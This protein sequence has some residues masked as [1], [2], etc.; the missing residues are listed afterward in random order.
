MRITSGKFAPVGLAC[1]L[2]VSAIFTAAH[3]DPPAP[4]A[5]QAK[6]PAPPPAASTEAKR[7][8]IGDVVF[9]GYVRGS[10]DFS[11]KA[12]LFGPNTMVEVPDK[13]SKSLLKI[14]ADEMHFLRGKGPGREI[15]E[16]HG[17]VRYAVTQSTPEGERRLNGTAGHGDF[18]RET[19][20]IALTNGVQCEMTDPRLDGPGTLR[21]GKVVVDISST[22]YLYTLDGD[23]GTNDVRFTPRPRDIKKNPNGQIG[24]V[25]VT[26]W[27][28]G[29]FQPGKVVSFDGQ[30]VLA[31]LQSR[32]GAQA[33]QLKAR[34][35][36]GDFAPSG[37]LVKARANEDVHYRMERPIS[38]K[39]ADG[40]TQEGRQEVTGT[41][42]EAI[43]EPAAGRFTLDGAIDATLVN[44]LYFAEPAK[45]LA[46]RL[47]VTEPAEGEEKQGLRYE[48]TG[49]PNHRRLSFRTLPPPPKPADRASASTPPG[50]TLGSI[51]L[52]GFQTGVLLPGQ[53][54]DLTSDGKQM[55][56]LDTSDAKT[57][58]ASHMETHRFTATLA[59]T[60]AITE[61]QTE[62]PVTFHIQQPGPP[63][64]AKGAPGAPATSVPGQMQSLD[65]NAAKAVY[66][67]GDK[68][69][70]IALQGPFTARVTDP[71]HL[72]GPGSVKGQKNDSLALD[73]GTRTFDFSS[74]EA[75]MVMNFVPRPVEPEADKAAPKLP[76]DKRKK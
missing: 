43:F 56:L 68:G 1:A 61:A 37:E 3:A 23:S 6:K 71:E 65:G 45:L 59:E 38:R 62:G 5:G 46:S 35:I 63:H 70:S 16:M 13:N 22:P 69:Q 76:E 21:A 2:C 25:H 57:N 64:E 74:P 42:N 73:L 19:H 34:H 50:F 4:R 32:S 49:A 12:D 48:L 44:T 39:L 10:T 41:S 54:M 52:T 20:K 8:A 7:I 51:V 27:A 55:L 29:T 24:R 18:H 26:Q 17:H 30:L 75:T 36:Q 15:V 72:I 40:K 67:S 47:V 60:G 31:D 11:T 58:S 53:K 33:G 9:T 28:T 66:K 14:H